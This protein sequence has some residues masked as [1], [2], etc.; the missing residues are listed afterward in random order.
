MHAPHA[1]APDTPTSADLAQQTLG[2]IAV[3][4]PGAT[5]VFRRLKLDFCC[6]G[7]VRLT[8]ACA[9][10]G[11]DADALVSE[12]QALVRDDAT[13]VT[14]EPGAL[15]DHIVSR[16]HEG[17][18]A[19][20]PELGRMARGVEAGHRDHPQVPAGLADH[21]ERMNEELCEHMAKEE[22][23]LFPMIKAGGHPMVRQPIAMMRHE[24]VDHGEHLARLAELTGEHTPPP[25]ACNT[26]RALFAGTAQLSD[27]LI[28]H[29]HLENNVLFPA[30]E[31]AAH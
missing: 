23:V 1:V 13:P 8:E 12:L 28:Q 2:E 25:G 17:P 3:A 24:H 26:W 14:P 10:K 6:G 20:V 15:V 22:G 31:G 11:L 9:A 19:A 29:I 21:L 16:Y 5:A 7:Q 4:L 18:R 30:F 27:D